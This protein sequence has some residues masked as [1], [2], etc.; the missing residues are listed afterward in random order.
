MDADAL[1]RKLDAARQFV[2][3]VGG[4]SLTLRL[5]TETA[6]RAAVAQLPPRGD[7]AASVADLQPILLRQCTVGWAGVRPCD[8]LPGAPETPLPFDAE[9]LD[10]VFDRWPDAYD[11]AYQQLMR[12][13][14]E[15]LARI[16]AERKNLKTISAA[17]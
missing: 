1:K 16:E 9:L 4:I 7:Q 11:A 14:G 8:L 17:S 6:M 2:V 10:D 15:R 3:E 13:Y 12:L 5:P